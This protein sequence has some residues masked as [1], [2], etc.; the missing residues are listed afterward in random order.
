MQASPPPPPAANVTTASAAPASSSDSGAKPLY[1]IFACVI[2]AAVLIGV[3]G[4]CWRLGPRKAARLCG[5]LLLAKAFARAG[6]WVWKHFPGRHPDSFKKQSILERADAARPEF[7]YVQLADG[8]LVAI[9]AAGEGKEW[10]AGDKEDFKT[11]SNANNKSDDNTPSQD[12]SSLQKPHTGSLRE[13]YSITADLN[14]ELSDVEIGRMKDE[15]IPAKRGATQDAHAP[16][17]AGLNSL[18][19][20]HKTSGVKRLAASL[21]GTIKRSWSDLSDL[22]EL[23]QDWHTT[24]YQDEPNALYIEDKRLGPLQRPPQ[25]QQSSAWVLLESRAE[26]LQHTSSNP[27]YEAST[28]HDV[29]DLTRQQSGS[30]ASEDQAEPAAIERE[31][32]VPN[33]LF[34]SQLR[35]T[36]SDDALPWRPQ[37]VLEDA[38]PLTR[39]AS[40]S[41]AQGVGSNSRRAALPSFAAPG[42]LG[43]AADTASTS[44]QAAV[45]GTHDAGSHVS[46]TSSASPTMGN[47]RSKNSS[48]TAA[49]PQRQGTVRLE[50][51]A[52]VANELKVLAG[53]LESQ[54]SLARTRTADLLRSGSQ[55]LCN[56]SAKAGN[57]VTGVLNRQRPSEQASAVQT[58]AQDGNPFA[59]HSPGDM[60]R[61]L[62]SLQASFTSAAYL[63]TSTREP[64]ASDLQ[65]YAAE[66]L[67]G[68]ASSAAPDHV[69]PTT[70]NDPPS[71]TDSSLGS[72]DS[73]AQARSNRATS[74]PKALQ[75]L[76]CGCQ[77]HLQ[78]I[79]LSQK[80][81]QQPQTDMGEQT[82]A[83]VS[84]CLPDQIRISKQASIYL[85]RCK[86]AALSSDLAEVGCTQHP[87]SI[88][89]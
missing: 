71:R 84:A 79:C 77:Q 42:R 25:R 12:A 13:R 32:S 80:M 64:S 53:R 38:R 4:C 9:N 21:S 70:A 72:S 5:L 75:H 39:A 66:Y 74:P 62:P 43:S 89:H 8:R 26:P 55:T 10:Q 88:T 65:Q 73:G 15:I 18:S 33:P 17:P 52:K 58:T 46:R 2:A 23:Q 16:T 29:I 49:S 87:V 76:F 48:P 57:L 67:E 86:A 27:M 7:E 56:S 1:I 44:R 22:A 81:P 28:W 31:I 85:C 63:E 47:T 83:M 69:R 14:P 54:G 51:L 34:D 30:V 59:Y 41:T 24:R 60:M 20:Q 19:L 37:Q 11:Q 50:H 6:K 36:S 68:E 3:L 40:A 45:H 82:S 35:R 61:T 78:Y